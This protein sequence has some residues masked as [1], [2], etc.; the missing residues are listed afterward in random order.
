MALASLLTLAD[1]LM[2]MSA[3]SLSLTSIHNM[4]EKSDIFEEIILMPES[5]NSLSKNSAAAIFLSSLY[6]GWFI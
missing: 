1:C 6:L 5:F 3:V 2:S 4:E